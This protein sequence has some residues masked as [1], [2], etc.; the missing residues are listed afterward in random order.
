MIS[1]I[2]SK[3]EGAM[4]GT[5]SAISKLSGSINGSSKLHGK[6]SVSVKDVPYYETSNDSGGTTIYIGKEV[7]QNGSQ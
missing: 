6:A 5:I 1:G 3:C 4:S 2:T 7:V